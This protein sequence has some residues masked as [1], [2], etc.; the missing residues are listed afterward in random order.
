MDFSELDVDDTCVKCDRK[1]FGKSALLPHM[2]VKHNFLNGILKTRNLT[3][4]QLLDPD[5][6]VGI[7]KET[8]SPQSQRS[9]E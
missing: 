4:L 6:Q 9:Q 8:G 2:G 1:F 3:E 7:K 5:D